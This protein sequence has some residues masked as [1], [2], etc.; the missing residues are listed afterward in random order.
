MDKSETGM[1]LTRPDQTSPLKWHG[2]KHYVA[3]E[4][5][6]LMVAHVHYVETHVGGGSVFFAR[7][8]DD[9]RLWLPPHKGV[10]EVINDLD[11][12]LM[13]FWRTLQD[14]VTFDEFVRIAQAI[15]MSRLEWE[16]AH[17]GQQESGVEGAVNFF[18]NC[19]HS[20]A[21]RM[22]GFTAITRTRTR[23]RMNGNVSEWIGS[24]DGLPEVHERLRRVLIENMDGTAL[25]KREDRPGTQ[26]YVDAPYV[27]STRTATNVY[28]REMIDEQHRVLVMTLVR[29]KGKA[30]VSGYHHPIYDELSLTHGWKLHEVELPNNASGEKS[31]R[32]M[33][34]CL[35]TNY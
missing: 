32:R 12:R 6:S 15:P 27:H 10:S 33:T 24:V 21:G 5:V 20:L 1:N 8:P 14:P 11:G 35:W 16:K 22:N 25:I 18:V 29:I 4:I 2:G 13:N 30:I 34:E 31:K 17:H 7:D 26:F 28:A 9:E 19:R 3:P 23:R